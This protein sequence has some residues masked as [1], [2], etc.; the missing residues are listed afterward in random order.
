MAQSW[1]T[2]DEVLIFALSEEQKAAALYKALS[3]QAPSPKL[4]ELFD[5]MSAEETAHFK[6]LIRVRKATEAWF[7]ASG[8]R[9]LP[10]PQAVKLSEAGITDIESVYRFAIRG[11]ASAV[12]LYST[13]SQM[14]QDPEIQRTFSELADEEEAHMNRLRGDLAK[15]QGIRAFL[16]KVFCTPLT[17]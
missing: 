13:L 15:Q 1:E 4:Q 2:V 7:E 6:K 8:L 9:R 14:T 3:D 12:N 5:G 10:R 11:E 16:K 17:S